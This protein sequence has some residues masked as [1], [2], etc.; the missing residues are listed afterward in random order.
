MGARPPPLLT[1]LFRMIPRFPPTRGARECATSTAP[2]GRGHQDV[3]F[4]AEAIA[5]T[6]TPG[7]C[8][9][10]SVTSA[11]PTP[12]EPPPRPT[13]APAEPARNSGTRLISQP[14]DIPPRTGTTDLGTGCDRSRRGLRPISTRVST[15]LGEWGRP[16]GGS[17][18]QPARPYSRC[19]PRPT[20]AAAIP[21]PRA[22]RRAPRARCVRDP[23]SSPRPVRAEPSSTRMRP[24]PSALVRPTTCSPGPARARSTRTAVAAWVR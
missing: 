1:V 2:A 3:G 10:R 13:R 21:R 22:T 5:V 15:D 11:V 18:R 23:L 19:T 7:A 9:H 8:E 14:R 17:G 16:S 24:P 20:E 4:H 12:P 6:T